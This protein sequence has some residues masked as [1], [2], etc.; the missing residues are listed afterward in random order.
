MTNLEIILTFLLSIYMF[1]TFVSVLVYMRDQT[2]HPVIYTFLFTIF[3]P[4]LVWYVLYTILKGAR[5]RGK[6]N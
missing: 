2:K 3:T 4:I 6:S 5:T 1:M